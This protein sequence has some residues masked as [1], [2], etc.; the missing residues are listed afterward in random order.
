MPSKDIFFFLAKVVLG[1]R[2]LFFLFFF[3]NDY[4]VKKKNHVLS[5]IVRSV[6][7]SCSPLMG[8]F[9]TMFPHEGSYLYEILKTDNGQRLTSVFN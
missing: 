4:P 3:F 2:N 8:H 1:R 6:D 9:G 7:I 5:W